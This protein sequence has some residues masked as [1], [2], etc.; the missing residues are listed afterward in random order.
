MD[1]SFKGRHGRPKAAT[2]GFFG[3]RKTRI[4]NVVLEFRED[5][6]NARLR[7]S[8]SLMKPGDKVTKAV[9][10]PLRVFIEDGK[11]LTLA[12]GEDRN[13]PTVDCVPDHAGVVE[14]GQLVGPVL[15]LFGK[16][17]FGVTRREKDSAK[18]RGGA[19]E[20][21]QAVEGDEGREICDD[22]CAWGWTAGDPPEFVPSAAVGADG[23]AVRRVDREFGPLVRII[24]GG[25]K[26]LCSERPVSEGRP[27]R[28][29]AGGEP[30]DS[31]AEDFEVPF[32]VR[33]AAGAEL[34]EDF[35]QVQGP[36]RY[37]A[38]FPLKFKE[39]RESQAS[40]ILATRTVAEREVKEKEG[41]FRPKRLARRRERAERLVGTTE[42]IE[43]VRAAAERFE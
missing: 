32:L 16:G 14:A 19:V 29:T 11:R 31:A 4:R 21:A 36:K 28:G 27:S 20:E 5:F 38:S 40:L 18:V 41:G 24:R 1:S 15:G 3:G 23:P 34:F 22:R 33:A 13:L 9:R 37:L 2:G 30:G 10:Y 17:E 43:K 8:A 25:R 39:P 35:L 12:A 26:V 42:D 7:E 6:A